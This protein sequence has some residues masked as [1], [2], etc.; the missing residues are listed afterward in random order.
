MIDAKDIGSR[1][2]DTRFNKVVTLRAVDTMNGILM[3]C[4][5]DPTTPN[6]AKIAGIDHYW[7]RA[8]SLSP[9]EAN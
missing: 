2:F 7:V 3:G 9:M 8:T 6:P 4:V 1:F 5:F